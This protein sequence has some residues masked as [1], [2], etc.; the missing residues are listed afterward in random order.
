MS[1]DLFDSDDP[2]TAKLIIFLIGIAL[3]AALILWVGAHPCPLGN[4]GPG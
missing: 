4:C 2:S 1:N 3:A